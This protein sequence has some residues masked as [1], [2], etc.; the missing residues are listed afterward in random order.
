MRSLSLDDAK[1]LGDAHPRYK[2]MQEDMRSKGWFRREMKSVVTNSRTL[3]L[4]TLPDRNDFVDQMDR[5]GVALDGERIAVAGPVSLEIWDLAS[6]TQVIADSPPYT[7]FIADSL[8]PVEGVAMKG[9]LVVGGSNVNDGS[10]E[11]WNAK[12]AEH[13]ATLKMHSSLVSSV[14][15]HGLRMVTG[16]GDTTVK[17]WNL[18]TMKPEHE[19]MMKPER[20][21]DGGGS[22]FGMVY[23]VAMDGSR[24]VSGGQDRTVKVWSVE[25]GKSLYN[26]EGHSR[27]VHSVAMDGSRVVSGSGDKTVKVWNVE[28]GELLHTFKGHSRAVRSVA[29]HGS[30][31]V[32]GSDDK[33]VKVWNVETRGLEHNFKQDS[34]IKSVAINDR[35]IVCSLSDSVVVWEYS[36]W[37]ARTKG[38]RDDGESSRDASAAVTFSS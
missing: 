12:T 29:I 14:A 23:S 18:E 13:L 16:S 22:V 8:P 24:V 2:G 30:R 7:Q 19:T 3:K 27:H 9:S 32:S 11:M 6:D 5:R 10:V 1:A 34:Y 20:T 26:L 37:F 17:V 25:T 28:K 35:F 38:S 31:V 36:L 21:F 33:T 4:Q 15:I